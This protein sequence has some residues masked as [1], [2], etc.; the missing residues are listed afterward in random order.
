MTAAPPG[1]PA[2]GAQP[3]DL[4]LAGGAAAVWLTTLSL[5]GQQPV[6]GYLTGLLGLAGAGVG[7]YRRGRWLPG[8]A[9]VFGCVAAAGVATGVR[10]TAAQASPLTALARARAS[11][12]VDLV[13]RDDPHPLAARSSGPEQVLVRGRAD[14]VQTTARVWRLSAPVVVLAP[15]AGWRELLPSQHLRLTA[16]VVPPLPRDFTVAVLLARGPPSDVGPPSALQRSAAALRAGLRRSAAGLPSG[17]RGL[18]PGLVVGDVSGLDPMLAADFRTAGLTHLVA[19]SGANLQIAA[20]TV[21]FVLRRA[22]AGPRTS[23]VVAGVALIGFVVLARPSPS[24]LRAAV[25]GGIGL[26][27]LASGRQRDAVP[28]LAAAVLVLVLAVPSL[29]ADA[30]FTLSVLATAGLVLLAPRWAVAL[31]RWLPPGLAEAV[32]VP[33]AAAAVTAPVIVAISGQLSLVTVPANMLAAPAVAPATVLGLLT[34]LVAPVWPAGA[35]ALAR[36]AGLPASWLVLVAEHAATVPFAV[37]GWPAGRRGAAALTVVL[38]LAAALLRRPRVRRAAVGGLVGVVLAATVLRVAAPGWPPP[39]WLLVA[40]DVGQGDALVIRTGPGAGIVVDAGPDPIAVDRC[41]RG[42]GITR[43][44]LLVLT[45]FH[46]DHVGG[47]DGVA[48]RRPVGMI[49]ISPL[50]EPADGWRLVRQLAAERHLPLVTPTVGRRQVVAGV[51]IEVLGPA[52]AFHGTRSDPNNSSLVLR[53]RTAR[54]TLLLAGDAEVAAQEAMLRA[55]T[56]VRAEVLK[57]PHHG[58]SW[59]DAAFLAAVHASVG[60]VSVGA[61]NDYGHPAPQVMSALARL[62]TTPVRTDRSGAIAVCDRGGQLRVVT[63]RPTPAAAVP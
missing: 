20:G 62:G 35:A 15:A 50:R 54:H 36:L 19:V 40:C 1:G 55:G 46:L 14:R 39:G 25:M 38:L 52:A 24:V 4:R 11:A 53:V 30:G 12:V 18:L 59:Q 60:V 32:A 61:G 21:L 51:S 57:V 33:A 17:A 3:I 7:L 23:A 8:A 48:R 10:D 5:L 28:A 27:A 41:L 47:V 34:A 58:S 44:P 13:V 16:R 49:E 29:A 56:D 63:R 2:D 9:L 43:I 31:R 45:H 26:L 6:A 37:V 22:T 42:L